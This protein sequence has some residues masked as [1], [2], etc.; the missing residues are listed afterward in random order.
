MSDDIK[1]RE[2]DVSNTGFLRTEATDSQ[3]SLLQERVAE[4][5]IIYREEQHGPSLVVCL[6]F[7]PEQESA[8]RRILEDIG[9]TVRQ[10]SHSDA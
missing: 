8:V 7:R 2:R 5:D 6:R 10:D 3:A 1:T 4:L 9:L